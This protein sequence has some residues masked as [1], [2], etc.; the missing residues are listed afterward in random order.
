MRAFGEL[1]VPDAPS[2]MQYEI[3]KRRAIYRAMSQAIQ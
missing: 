1:S 2:E 3:G